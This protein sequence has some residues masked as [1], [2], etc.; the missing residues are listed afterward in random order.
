MRLRPAI[1]V[2][3]GGAVGDFILTLPALQALRR[4]WPEASIELAGYPGIAELAR[5][6]GLVD[7]VVSLH[8]ARIAGLY[9]LHGPLDRNLHA[10]LSPFDRIVAYL[11]DPDGS[12]MRNLRESGV[13]KIIHLSP[14][15]P[16]VHAADYF[17]SSLAGE[18]VL[19][20]GP[21]VPRLKLQEAVRSAGRARLER[22]GITKAA[23]VLHPG[24]GSPCKN[25]PL[26][27]F[28]ELAD[29]HLAAGN[30]VIFLLGEADALI[31][32]EVRLFCSAR[33][34]PLME[35]EPLTEVASLLAGCG[36]YVGNDSGLTHL[37]AALGLRT[38]ALFGPTDPA[39]WS[40]RGD[41]VRILQ[42][43][44]GKM[45]TLSVDAVFSALQ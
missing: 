45:D 2:L 42:G 12:V 43:A 20:P 32:A 21:A 35:N 33:A 40:P 11:H 29:L 15:D 19:E 31:A 6:G 28:L 22:W 41:Q 8:Q 7:T 30:P 3:R 39:L 27:R 37:A 1:L 18:G 17:L 16:P 9:A 26:V 23:L 5:L 24:S 13:R 25:W 44:G 4:H 38:L 34:C 36:S 14:V 10:F